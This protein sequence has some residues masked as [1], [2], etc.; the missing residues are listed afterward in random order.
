MDS[1]PQIADEAPTDPAL[2]Q[3]QDAVEA[4]QS[5]AHELQTPESPAHPQSTS[6]LLQL[7]D[8]LLLDVF[9]K[10]SPRAVAN[11]GLTCKTLE[12]VATDELYRDDI[13]RNHSSVLQRAAIEN[14]IDWLR[15][16][17]EYGA[18][19]NDSCPE[20]PVRPLNDGLRRLR[21][22]PP[23]YIAAFRGYEPIAAQLLDS[24]A[25]PN[26]RWKPCSCPSRQGP[27][28]NDYRDVCNHMWQDGFEADIPHSGGIGTLQLIKI[29][30]RPGFYML[31]M[32][33]AS[34]IC[35]TT[36]RTVVRTVVK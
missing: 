29:H 19:V 34:Y 13:K 1:I 4:C 21:Y 5:A 9:A 2:V 22:L 31:T 12:N 27:R 25:G 18:D 35:R 20:D 26:I 8:E 10:L 32:R 28:H 33:R 36:S 3:P 15:K 14:R 16:G 6:R 23:L 7:P 17:L 11:I 24:G 30:V